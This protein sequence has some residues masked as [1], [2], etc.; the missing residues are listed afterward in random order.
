MKKSILFTVI[1]AL[2][3]AV[4]S[5]IQAQHDPSSFGQL[6]Q[7]VADQA[8]WQEMNRL[9]A[10][11][12]QFTDPNRLQPGE[13]VMIPIDSLNTWVIS[14]DRWRAAH[15]TSCLWDIAK[16]KLDGSLRP[17]WDVQKAQPIEASAVPAKADTVFAAGSDPQG[18]LWAAV[19]GLIALA[20]LIAWYL[21]ARKSHRL[22]D[23]HPR[24]V[25]APDDQRRYPPVVSGGFSG[26][27]AQAWAQQ[28]NSSH[29]DLNRLGMPKVVRGRLVNGN[30]LPWGTTRVE[31]GEKNDDGTRKVRELR[32]SNGQIAAQAEYPD[33]TIRY[34]SWGCINGLVGGN[35]LGLPAGWTFV[36]NSQEQAAATVA[37]AVTEPTAVAPTGAG[38]PSEAQSP[39]IERREFTGPAIR[40]RREQTANGTDVQEW[41]VETTGGMP[42]VDRLVVHDPL[43]LGD[44]STAAVEVHLLR[45]V[46][47]KDKVN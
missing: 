29:A 39:Q 43:K 37:Q 33:G 25:Y 16:A 36:P 26:T 17:D 3:I 28:I 12:P 8:V 38:H 42:Q 6:P 11:N 5:A 47:Q 31:T 20:A 40:I 19:L 30:G 2:V 41:T 44:G 24:F 32:I 22:E 21:A 27:S 46:A 45:P 18:W 10:V 4:A 34:F 23:G 9:I 7:P 14:V 35:Q 1:A 13:S 15:G